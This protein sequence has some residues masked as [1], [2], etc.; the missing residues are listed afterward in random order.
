MHSKIWFLTL[1]LVV[2]RERKR[3]RAGEGI[4]ET[5]EKGRDLGRLG[6]LLVGLLR[7]GCLEPKIGKL[8]WAGLCELYTYTLP[9]QKHLRPKA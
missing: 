5:K 4:L 3:E 6:H 1:R 8:S 2:V 7:N 9:Q